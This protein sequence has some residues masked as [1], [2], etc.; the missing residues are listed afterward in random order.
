MTFSKRG[1]KRKD[2]YSM[3]VPLIENVTLE[4]I[5]APSFLESAISTIKQKLMLLPA[6]YREIIQKRFIEGMS[7]QEAKDKMQLRTQGAKN[8]SKIGI[9]KAARLLVI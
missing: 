6:S 8:Y 3:N 1:K 2:R 7:F 5:Y 9:N 4:A